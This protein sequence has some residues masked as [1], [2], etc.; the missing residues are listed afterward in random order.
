MKSVSEKFGLLKRRKLDLTKYIE[1]HQFKFD[2]VYNEAITN[3]DIYNDV[4]KSVVEFALK[5]GR[6]SCFAYG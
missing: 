6:V 4:L 1:E 3:V 5:G 2:S